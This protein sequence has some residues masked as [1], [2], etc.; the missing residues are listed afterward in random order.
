MFVR[1]AKTLLRKHFS[2]KWF[3]LLEYVLY[4]DISYSY[5]CQFQVLFNPSHDD[6]SISNQ[7]MSSTGL[8]FWPNPLNMQ[9]R[10]LALLF[11]K[12]YG[13]FKSYVKTLE[14]I[15]QHFWNSEICMRFLR[16]NTNEFVFLGTFLLYFFWSGN[17]R[18]QCAKKM[19]IF[20]RNNLNRKEM[21]I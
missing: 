17:P 16:K 13:R 21:P 3:F 9:A 6:A 8:P 1:V 19:K 14:Q 2:I 18:I 15:F 12:K 10:H 5:R 4:P 20:N 11:L 7:R